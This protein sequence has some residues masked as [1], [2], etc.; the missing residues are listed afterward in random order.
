VRRNIELEAGELH[1]NH[2]WNR[3]HPEFIDGAL[4]IELG[5]NLLRQPPRRP[6]RGR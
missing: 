6:S 1:S 4:T 2:G 3:R 5:E